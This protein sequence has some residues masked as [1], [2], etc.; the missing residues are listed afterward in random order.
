MEELFKMA[1]KK[2]FRFASTK[3]DLSVEDLWDLPL[4][5][6]T[7]TIGTSLDNVAKSIN[8]KMKKTEE[9]SFVVESTSENTTLTAKMDI[10]KCIIK[11]K[12]EAVK[13]K[14]D[15]AVRKEKKEKILGI[16]ADK[17]DSSLRKTSKANL[18]KMLADL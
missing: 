13:A 2:K 9:E 5:T 8:R 10:V 3:G 7:T 16:L 1:S 6:K 17:E 15:L 12:K 14:L 4:V 11:E 18:E